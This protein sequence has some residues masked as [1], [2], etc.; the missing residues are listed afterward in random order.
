MGD[1]EPGRGRDAASDKAEETAGAERTAGSDAEPVSAFFE[2]LTAY[3]ID[4]TR[5]TDLLSEFDRLSDRLESWDPGA[6]VAGL[7]R[8]ESLYGRKK[9]SGAPG[10]AG[11][12]FLLL[13]SANQVVGASDN[14]ATLDEYLTVDNG[15]IAF[16]HE[17]SRRSLDAAL[18]SLRA[19]QHSHSLISLTH[20]ERPRHRFG[21][22][23]SRK[24]F[25]TTLA[26]L[27]GNATEALF[28]A[29][30]DNDQHL[31]SV[32]QASFSLTAAE[33]D[34]TM[35]LVS[36]LTLKEAAEDLGISIN[37]ARNHLQSVFDKSGI[38]RQSDLVLVVTQLSVILA[39][40]E[41]D[42]LLDQRRQRA[43]R[44]P[45]RH[46]MILPDGRRLAYRTY[47]NPQG[48]P[49]VYLHETL[50]CSILPPET[51]ELASACGLYLMAPERPG[52][53]FSDVDAD[54]SF[55]SVADDIVALMDHLRIESCQLL[56]FVSGSAF[57]LRVAE[58]HPSRVDHLMLVGGRPPR[59][60][61][62]RFKHLMPLYTKMISQPWLM[63]SFFNILRNRASEETNARLILSVYG[64][65]PHDRAF[66]EAHPEVF[67]HMSAYTLESMTVT[68]SGVAGELKCFAKAQISTPPILKMPVTAWHGTADALASKEDLQK[69]LEGQPVHWRTFADAGSLIL[70]EHWPQVLQVLGGAES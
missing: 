47:G 63:T 5:W 62:G 60:M 37:T 65:V 69:Y 55:D 22:L 41:S 15:A 39:S 43:R 70:Y 11:F 38:N 26:Q 66:L 28:I 59:P 32:V 6:L 51:D 8:A 13:D 9:D 58:R 7:S 36:G 24:E 29:R 31:E 23:I 40:T 56:G 44:S 2:A 67:R 45:P 48:R 17:D 12:V 14:L 19:R 64:S 21:F 10:Q 42:Q 46:F 16:R 4:P 34:V 61:K 3:A 52:F 68:A 25:P 35:R 30:D 33:T 20:P 49:V 1:Q 50:G 18:G 27:A 57:A 53:G 54:F